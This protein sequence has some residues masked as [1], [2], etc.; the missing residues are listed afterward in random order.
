MPPNGRVAQVV[1][2]V[3]GRARLRAR[4]R[5]SSRPARF[6]EFQPH[7]AR[8]ERR[9]LPQGRLGNTPQLWIQPGSAKVLWDRTT[10]FDDALWQPRRSYALSRERIDSG[11]PSRYS[12]AV[13]EDELPT[14]SNSEPPALAPDSET[15]S[16]TQGSAPAAKIACSVRCFAGGRMS[17]PV[18]SRAARPAGPVTSR[19]APM[20]GCAA[21]ARSPGS[22]A[23][24]AQTAACLP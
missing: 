18:V 15:A 1:H 12:R 14:P 23:P 17:I 22:N 21:F 7:A 16:V 19:P 9:A 20:N 6:G 13:A 24:I 4:R 5:R 2:P 10:A 8:S 11:L 3:R